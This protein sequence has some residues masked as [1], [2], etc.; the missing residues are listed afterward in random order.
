MGAASKKE[1]TFDEVFT[2]KLHNNIMLR[3]LRKIISR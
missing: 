2:V 3:Y 1:T